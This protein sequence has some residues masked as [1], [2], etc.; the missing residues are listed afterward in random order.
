MCRTQSVSWVSYYFKYPLRDCVRALYLFSHGNRPP[1]S[2]RRLYVLAPGQRPEHRP[3]WG[4]RRP[5][6]LRPPLLP[7]LHAPGLRIRREQSLGIAQATN[8]L[9]Q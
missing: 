2:G 9:D 8:Q 3:L 7:L 6:R 4:V 5:R 1:F